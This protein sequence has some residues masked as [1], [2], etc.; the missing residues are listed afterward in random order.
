MLMSHYRK[1]TKMESAYVS[2]KIPLLVHEG[3]GRR[4]AIAIAINMAKER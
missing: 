4:Q 2:H 1:L 3:Y